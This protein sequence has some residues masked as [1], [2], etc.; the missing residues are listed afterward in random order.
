MKRIILYAVSAIVVAG[1]SKEKEPGMDS[2]IPVSLVG[3]EAVN[4]DNSGEFP[5]ITVSSVPKDAYMIGIK[6]VTNYVV[7]TN[8]K[9]ITGPIQRG[10]QVY[11]SWASRYQRAIKCNTDF[12]YGIEAGEYVSKFFKEINSN[13]L[14][15]GIDEGFVLLAPPDPGEHSFRVEF[16]EGTVLKFY[17]DTQPIIFN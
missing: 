12:G 5:R 4:I 10:D 2:V 16:Y 15:M 7:T 3:I 8:D 9:F 17:Y 1:C 6:W 11:G 13:Y 14:P